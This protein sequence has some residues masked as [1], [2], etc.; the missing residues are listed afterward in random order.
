MGSLV[1]VNIGVAAVSIAYCLNEARKVQLFSSV[2]SPAS[3][4]NQPANLRIALAAA[5]SSSIFLGLSLL[6]RAFFREDSTVKGP[7]ASTVDFVKTL[8]GQEPRRKGLV[9]NEWIDGYNHLQRPEDA[10]GR[11]QHYD[12][13]VDCFYEL[14][15]PFYEWGWGSSFHFAYRLKGECFAESMRRHEYYLASWL[16][17][18]PR[19]KVLD[20]GCGIGGP[21]R[22]I[23]RV[24]G[25]NMVGITLN[26][27]QVNRG[28][29]LSRQQDLSHAIEFRQADFMKPLDFPEN[30]FDG[31]VS[32]EATCHS[33]DRHVVFK[34][35]FRIMKPGA[36]FANYEWC[37]TEKFDKNNA[38]HWQI[39]KKIEEGNS[40]PDMLQTKEIDK[41]LRECGFE[42]VTSR[43][44]TL[45][46][47]QEHAWYLPLVPSWNPFIQ[48]FQFNWLG[49]V[50]TCALLYALEMFRIVPFGTYKVQSMLQVAAVACVQGGKTGTFTP[51]YIFAARKPKDASSALQAR[52]N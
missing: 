48:R 34:E 40:L 6:E 33:P 1:Q 18:P 2:I 4:L 25:W 35:I 30:S 21:T 3:L 42:I 49:K 19:S 29:E 41:I 38:E 37:L 9:V 31:V 17:L 39:K 43:D 47:N 24:T 22:N 14:V 46:L 51:M 13:M 16:G 32:I 11:N 8:F 45:D 52:A 10:T 23:G 5:G 27:Y 44:M 28:T 12:K 15:T 7:I 50:V 20:L 36:V 26:E